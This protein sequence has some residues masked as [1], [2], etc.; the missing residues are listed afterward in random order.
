MCPIPIDEEALFTAPLPSMRSAI[1]I[2]RQPTVVEAVEE[3][4]GRSRSRSPDRLKPIC[5]HP[6]PQRVPYCGRRSG[7]HSHSRSSSPRWRRRYRSKSRSF[8]PVGRP[9]VINI[10]PSAPSPI[11][12]PIAQPGPSQVVSPP[13]WYA[14]PPSGLWPTQVP[15]QPVDILT[16]K[17]NKSLAYVPTTKTYDVR[18]LSLWFSSFVRV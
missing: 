6:P 12:I 3:D 7:S 13:S 5:I 11:P 18:P 4:R 16:F 8:S 1:H 9:C 15:K 14:T 17:Y 10:L 2:P